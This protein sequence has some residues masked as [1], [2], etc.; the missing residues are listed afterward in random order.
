[1][2]DRDRLPGYSIKSGAFVVGKIVKDGDGMFRKH[3]F[4]ITC[5]LLF[6]LLT[7]CAGKSTV[8]VYEFQNGT[9]VDLKTGDMLVITLDGNPTTGYQW[10]MLPNTDGVVELQGDPEYKSGGNLVGSGGKYNFNVKAVKAGTTRVDLKYYRSFEAGV[11][12]IQTFSIEIT[13]K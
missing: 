1:M 2:D 9:S 4:I 5:I 10:E 12:P 6:T 3:Q 11:P 13:V 7:G 8:N